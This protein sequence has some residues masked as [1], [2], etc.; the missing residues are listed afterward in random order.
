MDGCVSSK[1]DD[2]NRA[3]QDDDRD[4]LDL[5]DWEGGYVGREDLLFEPECA[6]N[7][8]TDLSLRME[9]DVA[10]LLPLPVEPPS[11]LVG[12]AVACP[13]I[14]VGT[15][16]NEATAAASGPS[17]EPALF[18]HENHM[19]S[20]G[21]NQPDCLRFDSASS[22]TYEEHQFSSTPLALLKHS[23]RPLAEPMFNEPVHSSSTTLSWPTRTSYSGLTDIVSTLSNCSPAH[24]LEIK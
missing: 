16:V 7:S 18:A 11:T 12:S 19:I 1:E 9:N 3:V 4:W 17:K 14:E 23:E 10:T 6:Q 13:F 5:V 21:M 20:L 24:K 2:A 15:S 22:L 8:V